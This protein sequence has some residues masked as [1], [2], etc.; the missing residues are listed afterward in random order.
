MR[1]SIGGRSV[2]LLAVFAAG[3]AACTVE[4]DFGRR[5]PSVLVDST[6]PA[7]GRSNAAQRGEPVSSFMLT[8][9]ERELRDRAWRFLSPAFPDSNREVVLAEL[10]VARVIPAG[11]SVPAPNA[12]YLGLKSESWNS[13]K[14]P[15]H[16][17][18]DDM[19]ADVKLLDP[20]FAVLDRVV[21][22]DAIRAKGL[23]YIAGLTPAERADALARIAENRG[24]AWWVA[25]TLTRRI[26]AYRYA[27]QRLFIEIPERD[28]VSAE[29]VLAILESRAGAA[30]SAP[31]VPGSAASTTGRRSYHPWPTDATVL[32]K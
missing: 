13:S 12:Y 31:L 9:D 18:I 32:Q 30:G 22:A 24:L 19:T 11:A 14:P 27:L 3:L 29:R 6:L 8:D 20:Y 2:L 5:Q 7:I 17:L 10:R 26:A 4:G 25:E 23:P 28:A 21:A 15:Y 16:R 1:R